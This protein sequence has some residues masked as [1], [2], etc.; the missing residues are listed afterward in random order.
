LTHKLF[1][2]STEFSTKVGAGGYAVPILVW[3]NAVGACIIKQY[4]VPAE[5]WTQ[6][7]PGREVDTMNRLFMRAR[8]ALTAGGC[9]LLSVV[10][11]F[12][13]GCSTPQVAATV[14]G[15]EYTT[16]EY[17]AYLY[18]ELN[19]LISQNYTFSYYLQAGYDILSL[20]LPYGEGDEQETI[21]V[22]EYLKRATKDTMV[23]QKAM[24]NKIAEYGLSHNEEDLAEYEKAV[25]AMTGDESASLGFNKE[26]YQKMYKAVFLNESTLFFGLYDEGGQRAVSEADLR[27]YFDENYLSYKII[28]IALTNDEGGE[29][30]EDEIAEVD[31]QLQGY[32]DLYTQNGDF[33]AVID[34]YTADTT[35]SEDD[36]EAETTAS[37]DEGTTDSE[38]EKEE[39]ENLQTIDA[40]LYGDEEF[41]EAIKTL[42]ENKA[43]ILTYKKGG[44]TNTKALVLRLNPE[45][46]TEGLYED[47]RDSL[48]YGIKYEE[49]L[50]EMQEYAATLE[51]DFNTGVVNKCAPAQLM[52]DMGYD[53]QSM[54]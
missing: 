24:A 8:R 22:E 36:T 18:N 47:S 7:R 11:L 42:E 17:I 1:I 2:L 28:E 5:R 35:E 34:K 9:L 15:Q 20:T 10:M 43:G 13:A 3:T 32:L 14:D 25:A 19:M 38:E 31:K 39:D 49:F 51:A 48:L 44:T 4:H 45:E 27:S 23:L 52:K 54:V 29:M 16:G 26:S 37:S 53:L 21:T 41:T 6:D 33:D 40:S 46:Q 30:T 50:D 12:T